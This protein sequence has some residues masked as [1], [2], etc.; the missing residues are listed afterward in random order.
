MKTTKKASLL[1]VL[2][3]L[4]LYSCENKE[5]KQSDNKAKTESS[6]DTEMDTK[7]SAK[8]EQEMIVAKMDK[9]KIVLTNKKEVVSMLEKKM[10]ADQVSRM[11]MSSLKIDVSK[12][13]DN[14]K[15][16]VVQLIISSK[17]KTEKTAYL[18]KRRAN[19]Y[20]VSATATTV[21]CKGCATGC[22]PKRAVD[23]TGYCTACHAAD[24][25]CEKTETLQATAGIEK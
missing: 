12:A 21:S 6:T 11:D 14:E 19:G 8:K 13:T 1:L 9:G 2:C 3:L 10:T 20:D 15:I 16:E 5:N 4:F 25:K 22:N 17:D 24:G 7:K 23:G 18:L